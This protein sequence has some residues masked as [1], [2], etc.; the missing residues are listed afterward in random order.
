[1][2][3]EIRNKLIDLSE[4]DYKEFTKTLCPDTK[5]KILGIRIPILRSLAKE[6]IKKYDWKKYIQS[7]E[8]EFFEEILL[9]GFII[10]YSK[11]DF[12]EKLKYIKNFVPQIDSWEITDTFVPTL[13]IKKENLDEYWEFISKYFCSKEQFE[14][15]FAIIS[16]LDY[17]ITEN[18]IDSVLSILKNINNEGYYCKM[19]VAWTLAE[20]GIKYNEKLMKFLEQNKYNINQFTYNKTLQKM[21]ES[22]R[23]DNQQKNTLRTM[24]IK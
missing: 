1:M 13:K 16:L 19:A 21:I 9:Q 22:N 18:Y 6:I 4:N 3:Q 15:R 11:I 17:Y 14:V 2:I 7:N 20:I 8:I 24:K 12:C 23:I 5:R 10:G